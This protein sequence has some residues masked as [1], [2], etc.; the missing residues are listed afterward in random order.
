LT[1][2]PDIV[3]SRLANAFFAEANVGGDMAASHSSK[4]GGSG[5]M[6]LGR[7]LSRI[8][9]DQISLGRHRQGGL[10][11]GGRSVLTSSTLGFSP[12]AAN[13]ALHVE[14]KELDVE[15]PLSNITKIEVRRGLITD[16]IDIGSDR[17]GLTMRCFK[18]KSFA[19]AI[20]TAR[21]A[22]R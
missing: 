12:N 1:T 11:V 20:E 21:A 18:A 3:D 15:I 6:L 9:S 2:S 22:L 8:I 10:W 14:P 17:G 16:I 19:A 7:P 13:R 4:T 5:F